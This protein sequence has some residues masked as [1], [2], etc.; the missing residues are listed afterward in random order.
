MG[1]DFQNAAMLPLSAGTHFQVEDYLLD[2]GSPIKAGHKV[3]VLGADRGVGAC[4]V[5]LLHAKGCEVTAWCAPENATYC[6]AMG[7]RIQLIP[8]LSQMRMV[9]ALQFQMIGPHHGPSIIQIM[10]L[11]TL[12]LDR[13]NITGLSRKRYS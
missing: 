10:F 13:V 8:R 2:R 3:M 7:A 9:L 5:Q 1:I 11:T 12:C 6:V 4:A